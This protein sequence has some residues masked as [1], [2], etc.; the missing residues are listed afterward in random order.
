MGKS[1]I[2]N[3]KLS[4]FKCWSERTIAKSIACATNLIMKILYDVRTEIRFKKKAVFFYFN[5]VQ[6]ALNVNGSNCTV[7]QN[8]FF[9]TFE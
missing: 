1:N 5:Y 4:K 7:T 2:L 3:S 6:V 8:N 9:F